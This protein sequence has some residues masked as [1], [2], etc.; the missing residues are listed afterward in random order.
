MGPVA[1]AASFII[2][3]AAANTIKGF[4]I[5]TVLTVGAQMAFQA[6]SPKPKMGADSAASGVE[7][8]RQLGEATPRAIALGWTIV[9]GS[10]CALWAS[11]DG[12][13]NRFNTRVIVVSDWPT[14][15]QKVWVRGRELTFEGDINT[16]WFACN[17]YRSKQGAARVWMRFIRG[18]WNQAADPLLISYANANGSWTADDRLRGVSALLIRR[19]YDVDA[20][21][22]GAPDNDDLRVEVRN[23]PV[24]DWR[25]ATQ[26]LTD[27]TTW[28]PSENP[29]VLLENA[30]SL[31]RAPAQFSPGSTDPIVGPGLDF[32]RRPLAKLTAMAN[33]CD[34][35]VSGQPR[36]RAGGVVTSTMNGRAIIERFAAAC[37]GSWVSSGE[38]GY[39]RPGHVPAP[40]MDIPAGA[41]QASASDRYDPWARPDA[42]VNTVIASYPDP[43]LG[44]QITPLPAASDPAW[45]SAQGGVRSDPLDLSFVPY[46]DQAWRIATR[47]ARGMQLMGARDFTGPHWL[48]ELEPGDVVTAPDPALPYLSTRWWMVQRSV[49][50]AKQ[51]GLTTQISLV[52][53]DSAIDA[54]PPAIGAAAGFTPSSLSR[55]LAV[56]AV[57]IGQRVVSGGS[58]GQYPE[59]TFLIPDTASQSSGVVQLQGPAS[60]NDNALLAAAQI[61]NIN[62][63]RGLLV[64]EAV[65]P[66]WYRWRAAGRDVDGSVGAFDAS[67]HAAVQVTAPLVAGQAGTGIGGAP[68]LNSQV[69]GF[70]NQ[71]IDSEFVYFDRTWGALFA[72]A[73][74][75]TVSK[76]VAL[77][78]TQVLRRAASAPP[79][80]AQFNIGQA[81]AASLP[82]QEGQR[83]EASGIV[84][85]TNCTPASSLQVS[86][87]N[88]AGSFV[89]ATVVA[90]SNA[91]NVVGGFVTVPSGIGAAIASLTAVYFVNTG[92]IYTEGRFARPVLRIASAEQSILTAYT[93]GPVERNADQTGGNTAAGI[94]GQGALATKNTI[95]L[96]DVTNGTNPNNSTLAETSTGTITLTTSWGTI[97]DTTV[98][99]WK[100][101]LADVRWMFTGFISASQTWIALPSPFPT[102]KL[103]LARL[104]IDNVATGPEI[105]AGVLG[106]TFKGN[107][108]WAEELSAPI[109]A[110]F[111]EAV[112]AG[113]N[114]NFKVQLR[115]SRDSLGLGP[116]RPGRM[117]VR[118]CLL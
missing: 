60:A 76:F 61:R 63:S 28:K 31:L 3:A 45:V 14:Q 105:V 22:S 35:L 39:L 19:E 80:G 59:L 32:S 68:I 101:G 41:L 21:Q 25:D 5:R 52:E 36:Y 84:S 57:T 98:A 116:S 67:W 12:D 15:L 1:A 79:A 4:L 29:V 92:G 8:Q 112:A 87:F 23:A 47:R 33:I 56:P 11:G 110:V 89:G 93:P 34:E 48:V 44:W 83:L 24:Y 30:L 18:D 88:A 96:G 69:T 42:A 107:T 55:A 71:A 75:W 54:A 7:Q 51:D 100:G 43:A 106:I 91:D 26:S 46:R 77:G 82:V 74:T 97:S 95:G 9:A 85:I 10:E 102:P 40:V 73:G 58:G 65:V 114:R 111:Q 108:D 2:K 90:N 94:I 103:I 118:E 115:V 6:L 37:A 86:W 78:A 66:G 109:Q 99:S 72:S 53:I 49:L 20:F 62:L 64:G 13:D 81:L 16:G 117:T 50:M 70:A 17:Q 27:V 38:G 113:S 104:L